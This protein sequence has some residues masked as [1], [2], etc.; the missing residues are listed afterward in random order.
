MSS[1]RLRYQTIEFGEVD[2]HLR[3]LRDNQEFQDRDGAAE[4]LGISSA[5]WPLFGIVWDA[6][7]VLAHH[8]FDYDIRGK[9]ILEVGCGIGLASLVLNHRDADITATDYHP[10]AGNFLEE[11]VRLNRGREIPFVR[12]DWADGDDE[13]GQFDLIIGSDVLYEREHVALLAAFIDQHAS[14][15]GEVIIVDPGR[16]HHAPFSKKLAGLGYSHRQHRPDDSDYLSRPF[17]GQI[18]EYQRH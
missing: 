15:R 9:R 16:G 8:M 17:P 2:I 7:K 14:P 4:K 3:T 12:T 10:E 5:S 18:I 6:G 11:N 1:L 13:L